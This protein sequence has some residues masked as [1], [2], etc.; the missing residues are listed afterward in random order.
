MAAVIV[1]QRTVNYLDEFNNGHHDMLDTEVLVTV[2]G[3]G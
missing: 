1:Y 2:M 3:L